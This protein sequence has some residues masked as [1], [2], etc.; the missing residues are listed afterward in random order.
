MPAGHGQGSLAPLGSLRRK[1]GYFPCPPSRRARVPALKEQL[2]P[3]YPP[4]RLFMFQRLSRSHRSP[5]CFP[6]APLLG[7]GLGQRCLPRCQTAGT[8]EAVLRVAQK[9]QDGPPLHPPPSHHPPRPRWGKQRC[10]RAPEIRGPREGCE[11]PTSPGPPQLTPVP[12]GEPGWGAGTPAAASKAFGERC[13]VLPPFPPLHRW[14]PRL[15]PRPL[16]GRGGSWGGLQEGLQAG[17][18]PGPLRHLGI[19][20]GFS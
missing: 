13:E 3:L 19:C 7:G 12:P 6:N 4:S 16:T 10:S 14:P 1:A 15:R 5:S 20:V 17:A 18:E 8:D 9:Q 11:P 2:P